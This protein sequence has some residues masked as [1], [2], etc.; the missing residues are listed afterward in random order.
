MIPSAALALGLAVPTVAGAGSSLA[1]TTPSSSR[2]GGQ[3]GQDGRSPTTQGRAGQ[4]E[5]RVES[6]GMPGPVLVGLWGLLG[7]VLGAAGGFAIGRSSKSTASPAGTS[8]MAA[9]RPAGPVAGAFGQPLVPGPGPQASA[10]ALQDRARLV[11]ALIDVRDQIDSTALRE[12]LGA[13]L[14]EAGVTELVGDGQRFD[15]RRHHAVDQVASADP[16]WDLVIART[17]R[18]GY[19]DRGSVLRLPQVS[20]YRYGA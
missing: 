19:S 6:G 13:A 18:P 11:A 2:V 12:W 20:V 17:E 3:I 10:A 15:P 8:T 1:E 7:L 5:D 9:G 14:A 4:T 16:A